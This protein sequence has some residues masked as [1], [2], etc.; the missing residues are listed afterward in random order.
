MAPHQT[1][2]DIL[3]LLSIMSQNTQ[4]HTLQVKSRRNTLISR[5]HQMKECLHPQPISLSAKF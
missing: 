5:Y 1:L 2:Q 4:Q 3:Q